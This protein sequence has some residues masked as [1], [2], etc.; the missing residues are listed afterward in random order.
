MIPRHGIAQ[1]R[2]GLVYGCHRRRLHGRARRIAEIVGNLVEETLHASWRFQPSQFAQFSVADPKISEC[3][4]C[5]E[6]PCRVEKKLQAERMSRF[7]T[8]G[9]DAFGQLPSRRPFIMRGN[10][11]CRVQ[12][13][14]CDDGVSVTAPRINGDPFAPAALTEATKFRRADWRF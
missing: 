1:S 5:D 13:Q 6:R 14:P 9:W 7:E 4:S 8:A 12:P 11:R 3:R 2:P 10:I